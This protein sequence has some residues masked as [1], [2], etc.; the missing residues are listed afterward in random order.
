MTSAF[1]QIFAKSLRAGN[2]KSMAFATA[3]SLNASS[4]FG[5]LKLSERVLS[6][7]TK[8]EVAEALGH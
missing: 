8:I 3:E 4:S 6:A 1:V 2:E 7:V 5:H